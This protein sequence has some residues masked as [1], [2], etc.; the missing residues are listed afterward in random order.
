KDGITQRVKIAEL[1]KMPKGKILVPTLDKNY[2]IKLEKLHHFVKHPKRNRFIEIVTETGRK[3]V[4]TP[5]HSVFTI[6]NFEIVAEESEKL[7][8]GDAIIIPSKLPN[9]FNDVKYLNLLEILEDSRVVNAEKYI[10]KA[11]KRLG[12]KNA[13][14][15][16]GINDIYVYLRRNEKTRIPAKIFKKLM[17]ESKIKFNLSELKVKRVTSNEL[18]AKLKIDKNLCRLL[19]YY[20]SEGCITLNRISITNSNEKIISDI[21]SIFNKLGFKPYIREIRG[22]G[23]SK[24]VIVGSSLLVDLL[25]KL[26]CGTHSKEKRIPAIIFGLNEKKI[27][28]FLESLY[29]GDGSLTI[30]K[31]SGNTL[32]YITK[33]L[34]LAN[35]LLYLLLSLGVVAFLHR[36]FD[37]RY[38]NWLYEVVVKRREDLNKLLAHMDLLQ[39]K[40]LIQKSFSKSSLNILTFDPKILEKYVKLKRKFRHLRR[41]KRCTKYYLKKV[42]EECGGDEKIKKFANGDFF[43]DRIKEKRE[44]LI[45]NPE[46]VFDLSVNPTENFVGGFGGIILHNTEALALYEA[47]RIGA[48]ANLV[49][50]TIHGESAYGVFDRVVHDLGVPST[51]FKATDLIVISSNLKSADGLHRFRRI[52][53]LV[54]VKKHWKEDPLEEEG[55]T[56]L[57]QYSAKEDKLKPTDVLLEGESFVLNEIAKKVREWHANW[58]AVWDNILLRAKIKETML[59]LALKL[60]NPEILEARTISDSNEMFHLFSEQ[61]KQEVGSLDSKLIY[62]KWLE[63]FKRYLKT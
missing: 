34:E 8:E 12:W 46:Y 10:R 18:P 4:V 30:S 59:E 21:V 5:E 45:K 29:R 33:S 41:T 14:K 61:V 37:K 63:W 1:E 32:K 28:A 11:I 31:S 54:E 50:G 43:I 40:K 23:K 44:I 36:K 48:L 39:N 62:E 58:D 24:Q 27:L 60:K 15:I 6:K 47:M 16:C 56:T 13:S 22:W 57:M 20:V 26:G 19:G 52:T 49:A 53:E 55:F 51:S 42:V 25:K 35:D 17:E 3:V 9:G 38:N 7:K 2:K